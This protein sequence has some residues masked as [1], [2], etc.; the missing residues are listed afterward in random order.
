MHRSSIITIFIIALYAIVMVS[1]GSHVSQ[2]P[3]AKIDHLSPDARMRFDIVY[4]EAIKQHQAANYDAAFDLFTY[5]LSIDSTVAEVYDY[6]AAYYLELGELTNATTFTKKTIELS[7]NNLTYAENYGRYL[8]THNKFKEAADVFQSIVDRDHTRNDLLQNLLR[9]YFYLEDNDAALRTLNKMELLEG[10]TETTTLAKMQIYHSRGDMEK[11]KNTLLQFVEQ[12]PYE[13]NYRVMLGNWYLN[14]NDKN[15]AYEEYINV[16]KKEPSNVA[17]RTSLIEYYQAAEQDSLAEVTMLNLIED[18][19]VE[20]NVRAQTLRELIGLH[21]KQQRDST[22]MLAI[23][24]KQILNNPND[25]DFLLIKGAYMS[26][27]AMPKDSIMNVSRKILSIAPDYAP[28]RLQLVQQLWNDQNFDEV[29]TICKAGNDYNPDDMAFYYFL[30]LAYYQHDDLD[31]AL[32]AMQRGVA[33]INSDSNKDIASDFYAIMGDI[34]H[35]KGDEEGAFVAYDSCLHWKPDNYACLNNYAY[36]LALR[37]ERLDKA[38]AM[39]KKTIEAE[40][41]NPTYLDTYAWILFLEERYDEAR[42][43]I[44][45]VLMN[46]D[47]ESDVVAEHVGD[48]YAQCG[49][50][51]EAVEYWKKA[52]EKAEEKDLLKEKINKR[53]Y[54]KPNT[55]K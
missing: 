40:P 1:C 27:K 42:A 33:Q 47:D 2:A 17:A 28:A 15:K 24:D 9:L 21:Q 10:S 32:D 52:L 16:L 7:P 12:H 46:S 22:E 45:R 25:I 31:N 26:L 39:S 3:K 5:C 23:I 53:K 4:L 49:M 11:E 37:G 14:N 51:D 6:L 8:I 18:Q 43:Y 34:L 19:K 30:G 20:T 13:P 50:I 35:Q 38:E 55:G 36:Y 29:I 48:I 41:S 44:E 54:I